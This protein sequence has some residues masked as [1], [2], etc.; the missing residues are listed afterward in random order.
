MDM[1]EVHVCRK[2]SL[3]DPVPRKQPRRLSH[4]SCLNQPLESMA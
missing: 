3:Q 2:W 1:W 4:L